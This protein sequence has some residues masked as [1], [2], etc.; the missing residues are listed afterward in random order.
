MTWGDRSVSQPRPTLLKPSKETTT[1]EAEEAAHSWRQQPCYGG[2]R[3]HCSS[4]PRTPDPGTRAG[5]LASYLQSEESDALL[6]TCE[7]RRQSSWEV[8]MEPATLRWWLPSVPGRGKTPRGL[9]SSHFRADKVKSIKSRNI[10][11]RISL[12]DF[13]ARSPCWR[14]GKLG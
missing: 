2:Q 13:F 6:P 1:R 8:L 7:F 12:S 11:V 5:E 10:A 4:A 3:D 14:V 9:S